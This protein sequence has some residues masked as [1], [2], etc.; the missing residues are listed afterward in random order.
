MTAR[1]ALWVGRVL[2]LIVGIT[3]W[4][5]IGSALDG[6]A[7]AASAAAQTGAWAMFAV[8][9]IALI[10]P[11]TVSLTAL[12]M[13]APVVPVV[14]VA[15]LAGGAGIARG[16][17]FLAA[18]LIAVAASAM[19]EL[20]EAFAQAS[21][22]GDERRFPL[23]PPVGFLLAVVVG[24]L[25]WAALLVTGFVLLVHEDWVVGVVPAALGVAASWQLGLRCH[26]LSRRWLVVVPAGLVVHDH[27]VLAETLLVQRT[28]LTRVGLALTGT[29][30]A[31]LTGPSGGHAVEIAV[32]EM[33]KITFAPTARGADTRAIH[34]RSFL[35]A[36]TRPGRALADAAARNL[37]V[38]S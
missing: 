6:R 5:A 1:A 33:V 32:R 28:T 37:P 26:R 25:V 24:W 9:V 21:A 8:G 29:E 19:G 36:P 15:A 7:T 31:D 10:V 34:A 30:A 14:A 23:R 17:P 13:V 22:Y 38:A 3:G 4:L 16:L 20:G 35:V 18:G 11:S 2:W 27:L 12:R